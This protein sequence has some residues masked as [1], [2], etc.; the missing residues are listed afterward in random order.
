N[1]WSQIN[2]PVNNLHI[3]SSLIITIHYYHTIII[4]YQSS[5]LL[6]VTA[7]N[8]AS[9]TQSIFCCVFRN[10]PASKGIL[11]FTFKNSSMKFIANIPGNTSTPSRSKCLRDINAWSNDL[12]SNKK[13]R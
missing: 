13:T 8:P 1:R 4:V 11:V 6:V 9:N 10:P 12:E 3:L 7:L 2:N 5:L